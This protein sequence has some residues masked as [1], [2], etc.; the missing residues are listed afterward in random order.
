M[1]RL[2][3][4]IFIAL[5]TAFGLGISSA[6]MM[7]NAS[8]GFGAIRLG[9]WVAFPQAQTVDADPYAKSHRARAGRLLLGSAEG[10]QFIAAVD[11]NDKQLNSA[12]SY[13]ISGQ[14]PIARF[15]TLYAANAA[16]QPE[17]AGDALPSAYNSWTALRGSDGSFKIAVSAEAKPGNW[18]AIGRKAKFQLV[19]N[20]LDT[21]TAGSSGLLAIEMP[22]IRKVSCP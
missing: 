7:L 22:R 2:P 4:L 18:L 13:E 19:L 9:P 12:C 15:W 21:P 8:S 10:L 1:F 5:V 3:I 16:M 20:L 14:T 11:E 6:V 17:S